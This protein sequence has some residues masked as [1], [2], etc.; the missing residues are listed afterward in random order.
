MTIA[1]AEGITTIL[2][3]M[4]F[5]CSNANVQHYGCGALNNL[6]VNE[7]NKVKIAE[8][9]GITIILSAMKKISS[10]ADVQH[11]GCA[12]L[13]SLAWNNANNKERIA[14]A[15]GEAAI[16]SAMRN[17]SSNACIQKSGHAAL[18]LVG[19]IAAIL[20]E[21]N[22]DEKNPNSQI[23]SINRLRF[24]GSNNQ[25]AFAEAGGITAILS[26]IKNHSFNIDVQHSG[27]AFLCDLTCMH[28]LLG[29]TFHC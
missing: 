28:C 10:N 16:E 23:S 12:A 5:H 14:H 18:C 1:E 25:L 21:M 9:G 7:N 3:A 11:Y 29:M 22:M 19:L 2:S 6:A 4:S 17:H 26:V 8:A 24:F 15:G 13:H 20:S 27:F